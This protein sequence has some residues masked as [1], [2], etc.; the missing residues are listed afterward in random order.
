MLIEPCGLIFLY[1][2]VTG[3]TVVSAGLSVFIMQAWPAL[4]S[5]LPEIAR[6]AHTTFANIN[7]APIPF[8]ATL[9]PLITL[10]VSLGVAKSYFHGFNES[11]RRDVDCFLKRCHN[12]KSACI[13]NMSIV[14]RF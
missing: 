10:S 14:G 2:T 9:V 6:L 5:Y 13:Q 11:C 8:K 7:Q 4:D 12:A 1:M 3:Q